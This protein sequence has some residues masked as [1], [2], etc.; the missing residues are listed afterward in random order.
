MMSSNAEDMGSISLRFG[1]AIH[2]APHNWP[3]GRFFEIALG[4]I[5]GLQVVKIEFLAKT[6]ADFTYCHNLSTNLLNITILE[7][8]IFLKVGYFFTFD[9]YFD[10]WDH[11]NRTW[12][13]K[14]LL[15]S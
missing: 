7:K 2:G 1:G 6:Y 5:L 8:L 3:A 13:A 9:R 14:I 4:P 10:A 11:Q 15:G 12:H